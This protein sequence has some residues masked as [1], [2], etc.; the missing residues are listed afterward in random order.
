[1]ED[2]SIHINSKSWVKTTEFNLTEDYGN[3]SNC[4]NCSSSRSAGVE[5]AYEYEYAYE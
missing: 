5:Q 3:Y 1:M 2:D 4:G